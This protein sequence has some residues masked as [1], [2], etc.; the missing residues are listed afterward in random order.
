MGSVYLA[1]GA[2]VH[3][4]SP[5]AP[6]VETLLAGDRRPVEP[7]E[8]QIRAAGLV[9][10][11]ERELCQLSALLDAAFFALQQDRI[12][13]AFKTGRLPRLTA[14]HALSA[15]SLRDAIGRRRALLNHVWP[16]PDVDTAAVTCRLGPAGEARRMPVG[17]AEQHAVLAAA[18]GLRTPPEIARLLRRSAFGTLLAVRQLAAA[19]LVETPGRQVDPSSVP[20]PP[21]TDRPPQPL[22]RTEP[23]HDPSDPEVAL[24]LRLR[25]ALEARL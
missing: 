23:R 25:A 16:W 22:S 12:R 15:D 20:D 19:G 7:R 17:T 3:A 13:L 14:V 5:F 18:D 11:A 10:A 24:L 6:D 8:A 1:E 4:E 9:S 21:A 2:V